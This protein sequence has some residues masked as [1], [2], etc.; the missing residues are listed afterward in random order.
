MTPR[1]L[2][3]LPHA[4]GTATV[5]DRLCAALPSGIL[6]VPLEL[7]GRGRRWRETA[8]TTIDEAADDLAG[9]VTAAFPGEVAVFGHSLGAY[10]GLALAARLADGGTTRCTTLFAS[11]NA[12]PYSA[13]LPSEVPPLLT[14]DDEIFAIAERSGGEVLPQIREHPQLRTRAADLLRA[15]FAIG[16]SFLRKRRETATAADLVVICGTED[17][18]AGT[19]LDDWRHS[20]RADTEVVRLPGGHFYLEQPE[21]AAALAGMITDRLCA[22]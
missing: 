14:T 5:F 13:E 2:I 21:Q 6:P 4:G 22:P 20:S 9:Q 19:P 17:V 10:L 15:D 7:P 16:D 11:A 12:A 8:V 1:P 18:F 3:M